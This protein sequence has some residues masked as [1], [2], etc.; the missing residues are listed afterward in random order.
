MV[1]G[2]YTYLRAHLISIWKK[3]RSLSVGHFPPSVS[4]VHTHA[5]SLKSS[6]ISVSINSERLV[7]FIT[8]GAC[9]RY[10]HT[11]SKCFHKLPRS[12]P[13]RFGSATN[14]SSPPAS[15]S[16]R[17]FNSPASI[18]CRILS[19]LIPT[20]GPFYLLLAQAHA[21]RYKR[22]PILTLLLRQHLFP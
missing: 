10:P 11:C 16:I 12:T 9:P 21:F 7:L 1:R 4:L 15:I 22:Y 18:S 20:S 3:S 6:S 17:N 14:D 13:V 2:F 8:S 19:I 5:I